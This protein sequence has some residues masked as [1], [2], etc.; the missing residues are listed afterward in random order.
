MRN[1]QQQQQIPPSRLRSKVAPDIHSKE[2]FPNLTSTKAEIRRT[3]NEGT[4]EMVAPNKAG[5]QRH[6]EQT[7][8]S[9]QGPKLNLENRYNTLSNDS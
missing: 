3:R 9:N 7:K 2:Y 6:A 5:S 1:S 4:F 8:Y